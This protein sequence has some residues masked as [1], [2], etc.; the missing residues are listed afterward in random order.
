MGPIIIA[1][2]H[3]HRQLSIETSRIHD[4]QP[5]T[6]RTRNSRD[7]SV[8]PTLTDPNRISYE[9][10]KII[11]SRVSLMDQFWIEQMTR[12]FRI[13]YYIE[14]QKMTCGTHARRGRGDMVEE[15]I[16]SHGLDQCKI[17]LRKF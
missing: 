15:R 4:E 17:D 12:I 13:M 11:W 6:T 16:V 3:I 10:H 2:I 9:A 1:E 7:D 14:E 8:Q 5:S